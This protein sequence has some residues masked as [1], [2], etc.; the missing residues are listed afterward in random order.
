MLQ[1]SVRTR[2]VDGEPF[3]YL[4]TCVPQSISL[5]FARQELASRPLLSLLERTGV[6]VEHPRRISAGLA[7]PDVAAALSVRTRT[8][9]IE[10][11]RVVYDQSGHGIE[12][13]H[14]L[15]RPDRYA[16]EIDL[17]RSGTRDRLWSPMVR[18]SRRAGDTA[19]TTRCLITRSRPPDLSDAVIGR[20]IN[21]VG[22]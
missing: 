19:S 12:D 9:L 10:L 20:G 8:P 18:Q 5:T 22:Y 11:T 17:A 13:L 3:S 6:K 4:T 16:L 2:S 7:A 1:R 14:A 21:H 15:C